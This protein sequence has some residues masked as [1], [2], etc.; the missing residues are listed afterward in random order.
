LKNLF[1]SSNEVLVQW[2][3]LSWVNLSE[4]TQLAEGLEGP[5]QFFYFGL[6]VAL[7]ISV[8][9]TTLRQILVRRELD[10]AAKVLGERVRMANP[11]ASDYFEL[12]TILMK[13]KLYT[14]ATR[15]LEKCAKLWD[16]EEVELAQVYNA[17]G[18]AYADLG[19]LNK[20][21]ESF[22]KALSLQPGY[23]IAYN[24][25]G[26]VYERMSDFRSALGCY[27][28]TLLYDQ[29]N[30]VALRLKK[31]CEVKLQRLEDLQI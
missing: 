11:S 30:S 27:K 16:N 15:N 10:D 25:L 9:Y 24:N 8:C 2:K 14:Q 31:I 18:F 23:T 4:V 6:L 19:R 3:E 28:E 7:L 1:G 29:N 17:L 22:R 20:A 12:G 21:I 26:D 13:K 5:V